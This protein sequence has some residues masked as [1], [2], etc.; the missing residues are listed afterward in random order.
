VANA[1]TMAGVQKMRAGKD[2]YYKT[3]PGCPG[4][5]V[6][7]EPNGYK[8]WTMR[9]QENGA[10]L[11]LTL[12]PVD[13]SGQEREAEPQI[14]DP[15]SLAAA[16]R[17]TA[18]VK[19][20]RKLGHKF[21][22]AK[23][24]QKFE[25]Q[26]SNARTFSAAALDFVEQHSKRH[27]RGW[28]LQARSL[29]VRPVQGV[30]GLEPI[31]GGLAD[32]WQNRP[33]AGIDGD[34]IH[35]LVREVRERGVPGLG[36]RNLGPSE[37]RARSVYADLSKF[38][39]WCV[40]ERRLKTNPV[41]GVAKPKPPRSRERVLSDQ[42]IAWLWQSCEELPE[43]FGACLKT[44]VLT[45]ARRNEAAGMRRSELE[46]NVWTLPGDRSK[47][48]RAH[49]LP[50]PPLAME[51][52]E[53]VPATGDLIFSTNSRTPIS[54]WSKAKTRLVE[55][56]QRLAGETKIK[57][58][59]IHDIRRSTATKLA[60]LGVAPHVIESVLNHVSGFRSGVSGTYNRNQYL[61]EKKAALERWAVHLQG[62]V[63]GRPANVVPMQ[64]A[65]T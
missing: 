63:S 44:L 9:F 10:A 45:A 7:V 43:P 5:S 24:R 16:R 2:R 8:R 14:G 26:A 59:T 19:R 49:D 57:P 46:G 34:D 32:R 6:C 56:M 51:I 28:L 1:F 38:F 40:E 22:A 52:I 23:E 39:A 13:F 61:P 55:V 29:G 48:H 30:T 27:V 11:R 54:G 3:D 17:L 50:L 18:D 60:E 64:Q 33:L 12:G 42:E 41:I 25:R 20:K 53:G 62:L 58:W 21:R 36:R 65:G 15:L 35:A 4:L 37:P 31:P 47:N